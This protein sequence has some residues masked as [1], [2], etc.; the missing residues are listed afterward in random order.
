MHDG[1]GLDVSLVVR[2]IIFGIYVFLGLWWVLST[3]L[4]PVAPLTWG[5]VF[6]LNVLSIIDWTNVSVVEKARF[7]PF[8]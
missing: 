2:V 8:D 3:L 4:A 7:D 1:R 6:S 5:G